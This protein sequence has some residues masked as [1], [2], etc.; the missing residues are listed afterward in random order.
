VDRY[1]RKGRDFVE[2]QEV[3]RELRAGALDVS[4][5]V[6]ELKARLGEA[7][8]HPLYRKA[9]GAD[10][11]GGAPV[12]GLVGLA[13][14]PIGGPRPEG[15]LNDHSYDARGGRFRDGGLVGSAM[16]ELFKARSVWT[17][18]DLVEALSAPDSVGNFAVAG[19]DEGLVALALEDAIKVGSVR[20]ARGG[21]GT[22]YVLS[23]P[24]ATNFGDYI[25]GE[26]ASGGRSISIPIG[27]ASGAAGRAT[28]ERAYR[29]WR[30]GILKKLGSSSDP[31]T[32]AREILTSEGPE[33]QYSLLKELIESG[34]ADGLDP[35]EKTYS[36]FRLFVYQSGRRYTT[37]PGRAPP[38]G[39]LV[40]DAAVVSDGRGGWGRILRREVAEVPPTSA[41][42]GRPPPPENEVLVGFSEPRRMD[43]RFKV[44]P[45]LHVHQKRQVSDARV[46]ARGGVCATRPRGVIAKAVA[47]T[48][49]ELGRDG[50]VQEGGSVPALCRRLLHNMLELE[51]RERAR[52]RTRVRWFYLFN[53]RRPTLSELA[54]RL[55]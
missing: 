41:T 40:P 34:V 27:E 39:Y 49:R 28:A 38:V 54:G 46:L 20:P 32:T 7:S 43:L 15:P 30:A 23:G 2:I 19:A 51:R 13:V 50:K 47:A 45:P 6:R 3:E 55:R 5:Q 29:T 24:G 18:R 53:D 35:M 10:A 4:P 21:K 33:M 1:R 48:D 37:A 22:F 44:R 17:F 31:A 52:G 36:E 14:E 8:P 16:A 25:Q 11:D 9:V 42:D 26:A 12:P